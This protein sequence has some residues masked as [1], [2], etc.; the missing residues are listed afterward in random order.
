MLLVIYW[1]WLLFI[2]CTK[3]TRDW[4]KCTRRLLMVHIGDFMR[5]CPM[6]RDRVSMLRFRVR[7]MSRQRGYS[8]CVEGNLL[9]EHA[10]HFLSLRTAHIL[11]TLCLCCAICFAWWDELLLG[12]TNLGA[13]SE[14]S[15]A[16][17]TF[18]LRQVAALLVL[19]FKQIHAW[20]GGENISGSS[21]LIYLTKGW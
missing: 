14:R 4:V 16:C 18:L 5:C 7:C 15:G 9:A 11:C 10:A 17:C 20:N 19:I 6:S 13:N 1:F 21:A 12:H 2:R 8:R 3:Y